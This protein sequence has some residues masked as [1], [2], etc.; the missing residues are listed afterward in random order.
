MKHL[1]AN[2]SE[3]ERHTISSEVGER[4]LREIYLPPFEAAISE[5]RSWSVMAAYNRLNGTYCSEHECSSTTCC[6][7]EW[8]LRR[9]RDLGLVVGEVDRRDRAATAS[10]SRC[11]GRTSTSARSWPRRSA[12]GDVPDDALDAKLRRAA[13]HHGGLGVLDQAGA[14]RPTT[15]ST[16]P[17]HRELLRAA[18][19]GRRSCC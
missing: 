9:V 4:T 19:H 10:T 12:T 13:Q 14:H 7:D 11:P 16:E 1:A 18:G 3:F 5:A 8:G 2:E 17:E 6:I 15:P